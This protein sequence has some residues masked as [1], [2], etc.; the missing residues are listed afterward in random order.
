[1]MTPTDY[2]RS[3]LELTERKFNLQKEIEGIEVTIKFLRFQKSKTVP[4]KAY[5]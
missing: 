2:D 1:M 4:P 5:Q 3:I